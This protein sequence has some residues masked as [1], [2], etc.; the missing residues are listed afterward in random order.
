MDK[1]DADGRKLGGTPEE[2]LTKPP[3]D[4]DA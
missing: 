1:Y 4:R 2:A 3:A